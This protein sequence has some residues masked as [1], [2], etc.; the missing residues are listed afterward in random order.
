MA[1]RHGNIHKMHTTQNDRTCS[2]NW[3]P[4]LRQQL[5]GR[6]GFFAGPAAEMAKLRPDLLVFTLA[7]S[8]ASLSAA[9]ANLQHQSLFWP[10][11]QLAHANGRYRGSAKHTPANISSSYALRVTSSACLAIVSCLHFRQL[12]QRLSKK[13]MTA[14]LRKGY[15]NQLASLQDFL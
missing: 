4:T 9:T 14:T 8:A 13:E 11:S 1:G 6:S 5:V 2:R 10:S 7:V 15:S 12:K 3:T